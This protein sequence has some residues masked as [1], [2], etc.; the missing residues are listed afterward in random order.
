[1]T[2]DEYDSWVT[3]HSELFQM[4]SVEDAPMFAKWFA[5]LAEFGLSE[6]KAASLTIAGDDRARRYR[7]EHLSLLRAEINHKRQARTRT[8]YADADARREAQKC[9][10]CGGTGTVSVP[11][12][13]NIVN[14]AWA[15]PF[16][17]MLVA[18]NCN[19]GINTFNFIN[20][21][22]IKPRHA[23][24]EVR[25]RIMDLK[26]YEYLHPDWRVYFEQR[27]ALRKSENEARWHAQKADKDNP[28][29]PVIK[30]AVLA[31]TQ[32]QPGDES[33]E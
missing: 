9:R 26:E 17:T 12:V 18:C 7:T 25:V 23:R 15:F 6:V 3:Y 24:G 33:D 30:A 29:K 10:D 8:E 32:R 16:S 4:K 11:H 2:I 31:I 28:L 14:E 20:S 21:L 13:G 27:D 19:V 1:M 22:D 5:S